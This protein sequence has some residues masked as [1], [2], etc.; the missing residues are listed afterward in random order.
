MDGEE[1]PDTLLMLVEDVARLMQDPASGGVLVHCDRPEEW[2][3][4]IDAALRLRLGLAAAG[5]R[6]TGGCGTW[7]AACRI[8][9]SQT[10]LGSGEPPADDR[11]ARLT[12]RRPDHL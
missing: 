3:S 10:R 1:A 7:G 5:A 12:A 8:D 11:R 9:R 4:A 6:R 2:L